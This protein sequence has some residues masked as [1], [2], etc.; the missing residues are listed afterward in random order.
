MKDKE[1][2]AMW[3]NRYSSRSKTHSSDILL[4]AIVSILTGRATVKRRRGDHR[5]TLHK[6]L[7][8]C[9]V[10]KD[11]FYKMAYGVN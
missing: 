8:Q 11:E 5:Q 10:P 1:I 9:D 3:S 7:A 2:G 6:I 4:K